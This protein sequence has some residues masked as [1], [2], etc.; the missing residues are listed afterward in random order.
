M[1][2]LLKENWFVLVVAVFFVSIAVYYVYDTNKDNLPGKSA[3]GK[4]IVYSVD[5]NNV[6]ADDLYN[7][8]FTTYGDNMLYTKFLKAVLDN[9]YETTDD[10][11]TSAQ[12]TVD[13]TVSYYTTNY[14]SSYGLDYLNS[15]VT[16]Q[17]YDSFYDYVLY[18]N[19][20]DKL[21]AEYIDADLD[22]YYTDE[23]K[24]KYQPRM[25]SYVLVKMDDPSSP[26]AE[27]SQRLA[28]AQQAWASGD[29]SYDNFADF[30]KEYSDDSSTANDGGVL[31]YVDSKSSLTDTFLK[32]AL[33]LHQ[34]EV[35]DWIY[36][37]TY[38]YFIISCTSEDVEDFKDN[39][40]FITS[41]VENNSGLAG[42]IVWQAAQDANVKFA[43]TDI[44]NSIKTTL[45]ITDDSTDDSTGTDGSN[46]EG[47]AN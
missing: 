46:T 33:A 8:L 26:T 38:G 18:N 27:E 29:Y 45:G 9:K 2:K 20:L 35:S 15:Q 12:S 43:D 23:F 34:G 41:I 16:S 44:E 19:K 30:A 22:T 36:D 24:T 11:A 3:D 47:S 14:G 13:T 31:G 28:Q 7:D 6:S 32:A 39:A 10:M 17:G 25:I 4:Q 40:S 21:K 42:R 37:S 1:L 5:D